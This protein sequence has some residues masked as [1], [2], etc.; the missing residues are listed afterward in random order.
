MYSQVY[1]E[2]YVNNMMEAIL[3]YKKYESAIDIEDM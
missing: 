1:Y 2:V 3:E